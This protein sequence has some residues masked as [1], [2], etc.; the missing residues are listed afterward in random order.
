M[1]HYAGSLRLK[2]QAAATEKLTKPILSIYACD[3][4]IQNLNGDTIFLQQVG[5]WGV[6][7]FKLLALECPY[8]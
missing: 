4:Y 2:T 5:V 1:Y 3:S 7:I 8:I 6:Q